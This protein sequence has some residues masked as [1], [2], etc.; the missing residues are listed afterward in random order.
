MVS[1][2]GGDGADEV[3]REVVEHARFE[4]GFHVDGDVAVETIHERRT[5]EE[6]E[7]GEDGADVVHG[8]VVQDDGGTDEQETV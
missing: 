5:V 8:D 6:R 2:G 7:V 4:E 1:D 3:G